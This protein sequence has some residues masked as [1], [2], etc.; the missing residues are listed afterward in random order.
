[1]LHLVRRG[2]PGAGRPGAAVALVRCASSASRVRSPV[3]KPGVVIH[4]KNLDL[5]SES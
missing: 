4:V 5:N 1:M 2:R 3:W